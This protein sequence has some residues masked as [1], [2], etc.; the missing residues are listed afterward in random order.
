MQATNKGK[1]RG[2]GPES[3]QGRKREENS[4]FFYFLVL[5]NFGYLQTLKIQT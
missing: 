1:E 4:F 3:A 2:N 5:N